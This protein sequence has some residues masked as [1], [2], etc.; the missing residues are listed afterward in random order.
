MRSQSD[1][2][3]ERRGER[4]GGKG[5]EGKRKEGERK[6]VEGRRDEIL[7]GVQTWEL[8]VE[9]IHSPS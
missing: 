2:E 4:R 6:E 1:G 3:K 8:G 9:H 7:K 5:N